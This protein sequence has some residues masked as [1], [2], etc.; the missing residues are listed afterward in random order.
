MDYARHVE[1]ARAASPDP[2]A[3]NDAG[4]FSG[5]VRG[6][7]PAHIEALAHGRLGAAR[8]A[9]LA[10]CIASR[11]PMSNRA[12][13]RLLARAPGYG[14]EFSDDPLNA[15]GFGPDDASIRI[16]PGPVRTTLI[17][18]RW[19]DLLDELLPVRAGALFAMDRDATLADLFGE[20]LEDVVRSIH[21][22]PEARALVADKGVGG[23]MALGETS[24]GHGL[25]DV[26]RARSWIAAQ[27][28]RYAHKNRA[29]LNAQRRAFAPP[30]AG[31][32]ITFDEA[33]REGAQVL[34]PGFGMAAGQARGIDDADGYD[35]RDWEED[36]SR[37]RVLRAKVEPWL[38]FS[39]LLLNLGKDVP[40]AGGGTTTWRADCFE[41]VFLLRTYA[42]WRTLSRREFNDRFSPLELGFFGAGG[43]QLGWSKG[44]IHASKP[45][46]LPYTWDD[47][48]T[49][50]GGTVQMA[51]RKPLG[52]TWKKVLEEL[53]VGSQI[54]WTNADAYAKCNANPGLSFCDAWRNENATKLGPDSYAAHP[55][56]VVDERRIKTEMAKA[57]VGENIP[58]GY[59]AK[60]IYISA[61]APPASPAPGP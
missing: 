7:A 59:I 39:S 56:G 3:A 36:T 4:S 44:V 57:V 1:R 38:A 24:P 17:R 11:T 41:Y 43:R 19:Q 42:F 21:A 6:A 61:A 51:T 12:V 54:I 60:Y 34:N 18:P 45:G 47:T 30:S 32:T 9:A 20:V 50:V 35:A 46:E 48:P 15:G 31:T 58:R 14:Y 55:F 52:K 29:A 33:L 8:A 5:A 26:T 22:S 40:K 23:L 49:T 37:E 27:P 25:V 28:D 53:P 16:R 2:E 13:T 10:R